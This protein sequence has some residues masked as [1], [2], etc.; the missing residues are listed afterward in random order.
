LKLTLIG[1]SGAS[2]EMPLADSAGSG[3]KARE[4]LARAMLTSNAMART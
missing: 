4:Q 2:G 1:D 3:E